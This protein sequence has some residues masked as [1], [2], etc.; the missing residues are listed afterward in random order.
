[1]RDNPNDNN[2][3][4]H[5]TRNNSSNNDNMTLTQSTTIHKFKVNRTKGLEIIVSKGISFESP[6]K[7]KNVALLSK[8]QRN[9]R[10]LKTSMNQS[11]SMNQTMNQSLNQSMNQSATS[12][13]RIAK[14]L[15]DIYGKQLAMNVSPKRIL[16][17]T[18]SLLNTI[19][20]NLYSCIYVH[21]LNYNQMLCLR[22][23]MV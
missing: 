19:L 17:K 16:R 22:Y 9:I 3:N 13:P 4:N 11:Q 1:M 10:I 6:T 23:F 18:V 7:S 20:V 21:S 12:S 5:N 2:N 8:E 15:S 14:E